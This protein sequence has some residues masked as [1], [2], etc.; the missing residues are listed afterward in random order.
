MHATA[1]RQ[2]RR[3]GDFLAAARHMIRHHPKAGPTTLRLAAA[4]ASRM[5]RSQHGHVPFNVA[6]T[7]EELGLS[8]RT[9]LNHARYL[10]ELGLIAWVEH[11]SRRNVLRTRH[12]GQWQSSHGYR[13]T[14]TI[15]APVAPP[16]WD[17]ARGHRI[18]GSGYRAR[19]IGVTE[20]GRARAIA[21]ARHRARNTG[22][23]RSR[24]CTP[25]VVVTSASSHPQV[26]DR[27]KKDTP[28]RRQHHGARRTRSWVTPA[29]C[30]HAIAL[31]ERLQREVWWLYAAG[32]RPLAYALR[33]LIQAGWTEQQL[34]AELSTWGVPAHLQD[35][36][37]YAHHEISR[38]QRLAELPPVTEPAGHDSHADEEGTRYARMLR[39][40]SGRHTPAWQ[41]YA[42]QLRPA[43]RREL[44]EARRKS[45]QQP[46]VPDY[47]PVL[48]ESEE[49]FFASLPLE[50]WGDA[51]TPREIYA[52]RAGGRTPGRGQALP[53]A[54]ARS[55]KDL[56][57]HDEAARACAALRAAWAAEEA[58]PAGSASREPDRGCC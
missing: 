30:R 18:D 26:V 50:T 9:V 13:G 32:S 39:D 7:V 17:H 36:A 34:A 49:D 31:T 10:R 56:R 1:S 53:P 58:H 51:P 41:R 8:R 52:A 3:A 40:R 20:A 23:Q 37:A 47:R 45:R 24:R 25:S 16:A 19:L 57:D 27:G 21:A 29:E 12:S 33:P 55:L 38:R 2:L 42:Q 5:H 4:F 15:Y 43:L 28:R 44:A 14:A 46:S 11:G 54:D 48:R 22:Q 35:P 6:A